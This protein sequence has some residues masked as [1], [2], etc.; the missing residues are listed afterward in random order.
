MTT[1]RGTHLIAGEESALRTATFHAIAPSI[2]ET[3]EP[4]H[5]EATPAEIDRAVTQ[6]DS[7]MELMA[8]LAPRQIGALLDGIAAEIDA[9]QEE[10]IE[11]AAL[12]TALPAERLKGERA[13]TTNQLRLFAG[14]VRDGSWKDA[15]MDAALPD[16]QPVRR[17]DLRRTVIP[18]FWW[19]AATPHQRLRR[20]VLSSLRHIRGIRAHRN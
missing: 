14:L 9:L 16:R 5:A 1:P 10:L 19:P 15:R 3:L 4:A 17:P 11:R 18:I 2:G 8:A 7:C 12:E 6:A 20:G 13:R